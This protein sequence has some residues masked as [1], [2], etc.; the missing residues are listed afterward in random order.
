V[1]SRQIEFFHQLGGEAIVPG[2]VEAF[3][4][5]EEI[6]GLHPSRQTLILGDV[7]DLAR[8]DEMEKDLD[9]SALARAVGSD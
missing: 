5:V 3:A 4:V 2:R 6:A 7:A 9:G 8:A 1:D